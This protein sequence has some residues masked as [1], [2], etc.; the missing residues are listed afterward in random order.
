[1]PAELSPK[2]LELIVD[3]LAGDKS[4]L[5]ACA[6]ASSVLRRRA[7]DHLFSAMMVHS[8]ARATALAHFLDADTA[9][10]ASVMVL[11][12][13]DGRPG[14]A[15]MDGPGQ[16]GLRA[17]LQRLPHLA[18]LN[19]LSIRKNTF[20]HESDVGVLVAALP[21]SLRALGFFQCD[22]KS[23]EGPVALITAAPRL[24]SLTVNLCEWPKSVAA[25]EHGAYTPVVQLEV[26]NLFSDM[27]GETETNRPWLSVISTRRLV[28]LEL[29][30]Y[31][32]NDIPFWQAR[33]DQAASTMRKLVLMYYNH[34]TS[35]SRF[36]TS[37]RNS[38]I[39]QLHSA[40]NLDLSSLTEL[41]ELVVV[42]T[43]ISRQ[44]PDLPLP[45]LRALET[46]SSPSLE[47]ATLMIEFPSPNVLAAVD[48]STM[49]VT[50]AAVRA[51]SPRLCV[52]FALHYDPNMRCTPDDRVVRL[53]EC[54]RIISEA[55]VAHGMEK[56]LSVEWMRVG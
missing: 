3:E 45:L 36:S 55:I 54:E 12:A 52:V 20:A 21:A 7:R 56:M 28:S 40:Q 2:L 46:T 15:W 8:L 16:V 9:L 27:W 32:T 29:H 13:W 53:T 41:R 39:M 33:I 14:Q 37:V 30:L 10:G 26:L 25:Q 31:D 38:L 44:E 49:R 22:F 35:A 18:T 23:H 34:C 51:R 43:Q 19:L 47:R 50:C 11:H 42:S 4:A 17:L 48:W 5:S 24:R 1:M 6:L